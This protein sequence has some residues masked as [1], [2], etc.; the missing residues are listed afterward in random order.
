MWLYFNNKITGRFDYTAEIDFSFERF[1]VKNPS[2]GLFKN[3]TKGHRIHLKNKIAAS[4][5]TRASWDFIESPPV[6]S[7][8]GVEGEG[9]AHGW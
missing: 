5:N 4:F 3:Y 9:F 2:G 8:P 1:C 7:R 6:E